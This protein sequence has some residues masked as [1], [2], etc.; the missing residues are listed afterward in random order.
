ML[1][2]IISKQSSPLLHS[3]TIHSFLTLPS[4]FTLMLTD[5]LVSSSNQVSVSR[6]EPVQYTVKPIY[7]D[8][9]M[10]QHNVVLIQWVNNTGGI[11]MVPGS[12]NQ[13]VF[14]YR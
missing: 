6:K 7:K 9:P 1:P 10:D 4:N 11:T 3:A 14:I 5:K 2:L 12:Y 8:H 13:V